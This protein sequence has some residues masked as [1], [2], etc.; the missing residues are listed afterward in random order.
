MKTIFSIFFSALLLHG[1]AQTDS[2]KQPLKLLQKASSV[3]SKTT[4]TSVTALSNEDIVAGLKEALTV[5]SQKSAQLLSLK[6]GFFANAAI[7]ILLPPEAV[8]VEKT[9]RSIGMGAQVDQ[10][11]LSMNRAAEDASK[12]AAPIFSNAIKNMSFQD[13]WSILKGADTAA[14]AYLRKNTTVALSQSFKPVID[15]A[16]SKNNAT[17][18]WKDVFDLYN[19]LPTTFKK[20]NPDLSVYVT[21]QALK[22]LFYQVSLEEIS[23]RKDPMARVT[24]LLKKVFAK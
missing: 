3:L 15:T 7:K 8:K 22:G 14:T 6:D 16:L 18:Y 12:A 21:E 17:K 11:I 1:Y 4:T 13:A 23:I 5:G 10:A 19:K 9:L 20:I 24:D 2:L